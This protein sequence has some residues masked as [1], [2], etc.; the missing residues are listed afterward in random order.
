MKRTIL[1]M[2][3]V[4]I[5]AFT[6]AFAATEDD[7]VTEAET[8]AVDTPIV[9]SAGSSTEE[10]DEPVL[11]NKLQKAADYITEQIE[12]NNRD[13]T[14]YFTSIDEE[15]IEALMRMSS[16]FMGI[17]GGEDYILYY[18]KAKEFNGKEYYRIEF[19]SS[20]LTK[21]QLKSA[22]TKADKVAAKAAKQSTT[23]KKYQYINNW[24]KKNV[25]FTTKQ[26]KYDTIYGAL[27]KGKADAN[28]F[29]ATYA[30]ICHKAGLKCEY[31]SGNRKGKGPNG[32][33]C[34]NII[35]ISKKWYSVDV[36]MNK[37]YNTNKYFKC[38]KS[39]KTFWKNRKL[40][41]EYNTKAYK[42]AHPMA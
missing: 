2:I 28:A 12:A 31:V 37:Y 35:K 17:Y 3:L 1:L 21:K 23:K 26:G 7:A 41:A 10:S 40:L 20:Y 22:L 29:A 16:G 15:D 39:N 24:M 42:K 6:P 36:T 38:T 9:D 33:H 32:L 4:L 34:W 19:K 11:I 13:F 30:L 5:M 27:V 14:F 18:P 25:K 8:P